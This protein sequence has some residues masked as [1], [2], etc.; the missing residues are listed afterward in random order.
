MA[1]SI[2]S[3]TRKTPP[4]TSKEK[5]QDISTDITQEFKNFVTDVE[6]LVKETANLSGDELAHTKIKLNQRINAAKQFISNTGNTLVD[7]T[8]K[9]ATAT[10]ELVHEKP[11]AAIGTGAVVSFVLGLLLSKRNDDPP[12]K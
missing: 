7:Q 4:I 1:M 3:N 10:N 12:N 11:W 8:Q 2:L 9:A 6:R 5:V